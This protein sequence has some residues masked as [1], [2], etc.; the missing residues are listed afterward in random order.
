MVPVHQIWVTPIDHTHFPYGY[1]IRASKHMRIRI[2]ICENQHQYA[3]NLKICE[4][5]I[6]HTDTPII[7]FYFVFKQL[8]NSSVASSPID[9]YIVQTSMSRLTTKYIITRSLQLL[10]I[11]ASNA[12]SERVF[13]LMTE[14]NQAKTEYRC[15]FATQTL[16]SLI[17]PF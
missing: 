8:V 6:L 13:S 16:S 3:K 14:K 7:I 1:I 12:D 15:L 2:L 11:P 4:I 9:M 17:M 10:S 5:T